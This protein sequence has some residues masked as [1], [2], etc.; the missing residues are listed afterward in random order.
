VTRRYVG[1]GQHRS[2][3]LDGFYLVRVDSA[4]FR[5]HARRPSYSL[6]LTVLEPPESAGSLICAEVECT[7]KTLWKFGWF[8]RDFHYDAELLKRDE[9]DEKLIAGLCGVVKVSHGCNGDASFLNLD[10]F[11]PAN[12]WQ[13]M[14]STPRSEVRH[15]L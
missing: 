14:S 12:K 15:D 10:G 1:L 3:L 11:A 13:E 8:L 5:W 2:S 6:R 4:H 7:S 9:V